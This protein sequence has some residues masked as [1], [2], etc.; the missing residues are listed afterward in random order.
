M[1]RKPPGLFITGT[2]TG[3]GKTYVAAAIARAVCAAWQHV[4]PRSAAE[5]DIAEVW[6]LTY[7]PTAPPV[8]EGYVHDYRSGEGVAAQGPFPV[9]R[10][11]L[12]EV[13]DDFFFDQK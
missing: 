6:E 2:D 11:V 5:K 1:T 7:D 12:D 9:R 3:V 13:L 10:I 4:P 8:Y